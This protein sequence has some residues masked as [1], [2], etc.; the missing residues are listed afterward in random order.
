[1]VI[2]RKFDLE[3][4]HVE[5]GVHIE[6]DAAEERRSIVFLEIWARNAPIIGVTHPQRWDL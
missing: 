5:G 3:L 6:G 1:M 2:I 4:N